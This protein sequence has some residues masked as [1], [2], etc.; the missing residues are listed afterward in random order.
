[1][2]TGLLLPYTRM[3]E[4]CRGEVLNRPGTSPAMI[5]SRKQTLVYGDDPG[6]VKTMPLRS[7]RAVVKG[8][9]Q[10]FQR[11]VSVHTSQP[12]GL[13]EWRRGFSRLPAPH[14]NVPPLA[15]IVPNT[16]SPRRRAW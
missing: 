8:A 9:K 2:R 14:A 6:Q 12:T 13:G 1:M 15:P 11:S 7:P 3:V 16:G 4:D 5:V 10:P